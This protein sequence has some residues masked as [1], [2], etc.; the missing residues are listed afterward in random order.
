M[1]LPLAHLLS[2]YQNRSMKP[3]L[4][5]HNC[6]PSIFFPR[7]VTFDANAYRGWT[8]TCDPSA[9]PPHKV[10]TCRGVKEELTEQMNKG[11]DSGDAVEG[12]AVGQTGA[13]LRHLG[14][15]RHPDIGFKVGF[16]V[17]NSIFS[18]FY[19]PKKSCHV[20]DNAFI[21]QILKVNTNQHFLH[22]STKSDSD[23]ILQPK[24]LKWRLFSVHTYASIL[25]KKAF[26]TRSGLPFHKQTVC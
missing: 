6:R 17:F 7:L 19:P 11:K 5:N 16:K 12:R 26:S 14:K 4:L 18:I 23:D 3:I 8:L 1:Y 10:R 15:R 2:K 13:V 21:C 22:F 24:P 20:A 25:R 9:W